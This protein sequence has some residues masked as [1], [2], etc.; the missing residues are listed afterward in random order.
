VAKTS[1]P[2]YAQRAAR[3]EKLDPFKHYLQSRVEAARPH[4]IPATVL[5]REIQ[6]QGYAG[7]V[8]RLK[9]WLAPFKR[10]V[11]DPVVRFETLPGQ[12]VQVDFSTIRRSRNPLKAF[13]ATLGY[14]RATFV[15]FGAREDSDAWMALMMV[16]S[17]RM[18]ATSA[19]LDGLPAA[20]RRW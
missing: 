8:S 16:S 5:L 9:T 14:S 20:F 6:A 7:G 13:V 18:Q 12:Q 4:W 2:R 11:H 1:S 10:P 3:P 15:R 19:T 17:F